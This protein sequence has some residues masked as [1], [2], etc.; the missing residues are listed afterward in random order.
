MGNRMSIPCYWKISFL[1]LSSSIYIAG[2]WE[3]GLYTEEMRLEETEVSV[4]CLC[5]LGLFVVASIAAFEGVNGAG[6]CGSVPV[7]RMAFTM[8]PCASASQDAESPVSDACCS[9][10]HNLGKN[11]SC[12]CAVMLSNTAKSAGVRPEVAMTIPKGCNP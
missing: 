9:A 7:E 10:V 5:L 3:L 2:Q 11:P 6:E 12:L 1:V 8:A 4:R